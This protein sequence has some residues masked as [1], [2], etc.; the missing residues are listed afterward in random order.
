M[1]EENQDQQVTPEGQDPVY[2]QKSRPFHIIPFNFPNDVLTNGQMSG[3][4]NQLLYGALAK[5]Y[6]ENGV[7]RINFDDVNQLIPNATTVEPDGKDLII[8][9]RDE[10]QYLEYQIS[11]SEEQLEALKGRLEEL[12]TAAT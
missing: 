9:Y 11:R 6:G 2:I 5:K 3:T 7:I 4:A 10:S 8:T 12:K 1:S